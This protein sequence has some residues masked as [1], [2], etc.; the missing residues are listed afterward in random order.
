MNSEISG[1]VL[2]ILSVFVL[3]YPL[4]KYISKIFKAEKTWSRFPFAIG[5]SNI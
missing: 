2:I 5:K 1:V 4:G 3:A